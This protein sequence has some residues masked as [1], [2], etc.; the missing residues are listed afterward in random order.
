VTPDVTIDTPA[1]ITL[2]IEAHNIPVGTM[3]QLTISSENG[4][5]Q[6]VTSSPLA[7]TLALSTATATATLPPGFSRF[8]VQ[9]TWT[10]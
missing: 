7:G 2:D 6:T 9:A 3:V 8:F 4:P 5:L 10:P 1:A